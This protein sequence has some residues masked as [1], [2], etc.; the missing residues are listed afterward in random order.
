MEKST[1]E[2]PQHVAKKGE[3]V[4]Q[5]HLIKGTRD[6]LVEVYNHFHSIGADNQVLT[7][8][9]KQNQMI[10]QKWFQT[11]VM[12]NRRF[13]HDLP[14]DYVLREFFDAILQK[15]VELKGFNLLAHMTAFHEWIDN[16]EHSLRSKWF[17][18][19]NPQDRPKQITDKGTFDEV[20][21]EQSA[22][23]VSD[24]IKNMYGDDVPESLQKFVIED[25][26]DSEGE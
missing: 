14:I 9:K 16:F 24:S 4:G 13:P 8:S 6:Q 2:T 23:Q 1:S 5:L 7:D 22:Q 3:A 20:Q 17:H 26:D 19:Q 25:E 18:Q 21:K 12:Q 15:Q 10:L 11:L